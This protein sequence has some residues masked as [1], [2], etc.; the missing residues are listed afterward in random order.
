M[1]SPAPRSDEIADEERVLRRVPAVYC[2]EKLPQPIQRLAFR[3][4][5]A[6][7]DGISVFRASLISPDEMLSVIADEKKRRRF[8][9][10]RL[11]VRDIR[12]LGLS[13][14]PTPDVVHHLPGHA[15]IPEMN[16]RDYHSNEGGNYAQCGDWQQQLARLAA[17]DIVL[18]PTPTE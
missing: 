5:P 7:T 9:V 8:Y 18:R 15:S 17:R 10:V 6:D 2:D 11:Q 12:Q 4:G 13:V 1:S 3:P 16:I 14:V